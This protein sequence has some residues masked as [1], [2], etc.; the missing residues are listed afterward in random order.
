MGPEGWRFDGEHGSLSQD[1][2]HGFETIRQ[3]YRHADASFDGPYTIPVLWDQKTDT[4]VNNESSEIIRMLYSSFDHLL[5]EAQREVHRPGGGLYPDALRQDIDALN[6]WVYDTVNDGVYKTGFATSQAAYDAGVKA[7]FASLDRLEVLLAGHGKNFLLGDTLTE[8][9]VRLYTTVVRFDA[10]YVPVFLA[11]LR[12]I[13]HDYPHLHAWLRRLY[14]DADSVKE[15]TRGAF[16]GTTSDFLDLY[17]PA[18]AR[19]RHR[20][21][22]KNQGPLI[23]PAGP[24][25]KIEPM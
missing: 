11:N 21:V 16:H 6:A 14:W 13:R 3:L 18:Y 7:V 25:V 17:G 19:A 9:D 2:I 1:P 5:P 20:I 4:M 12:T 15:Q 22:Y 8:A 24:S 10:A 23:V